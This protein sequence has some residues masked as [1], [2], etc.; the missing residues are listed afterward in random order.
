MQP[1][2]IRGRGVTNDESGQN[3]KYEKYVLG[4]NLLYVQKR[5]LVRYY[6]KNDT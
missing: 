5:E 6:T 2:H 1:E 4:L 3:F